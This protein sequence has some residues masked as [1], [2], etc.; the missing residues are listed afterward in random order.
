VDATFTEVFSDDFKRADT[1]N[2]DLGSGRVQPKG[3][4]RTIQNTTAV[5]A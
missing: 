2:A 4:S 5:V 3:T 1:T